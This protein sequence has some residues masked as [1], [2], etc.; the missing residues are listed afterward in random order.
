[1]QKVT[2]IMCMLCAAEVNKAFSKA[3]S[4]GNGLSHHNGHGSQKN[5]QKGK[6]DPRKKEKKTLPAIGNAARIF[7]KRNKACQR[8]HQRSCAAHIDANQK[9]AGILREATEQNGSGN[10][11]DDLAGERGD[12]HGPM[13]QKAGEQYPDRF[14][15]GKVAGKGEKSGEGG[16][17]SPVHGF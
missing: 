3:H 9:P 6:A 11:A 8:S 4:V 15:P 7:P 13:G 1:M 16:Q 2:Q 10:I 17:Q 12:Q 5:R 14:H